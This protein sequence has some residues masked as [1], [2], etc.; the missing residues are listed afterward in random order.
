[1]TSDNPSSGREPHIA[2]MLPKLSEGGISRT[3]TTLVRGLHAYASVRVSFLL[4]HRTGRMLGVL[5]DRIAVD[6]LGCSQIRQVVP[7]LAQYLKKARPDVLLVSKET[8]AFAAMIAKLIARSPVRIFPTLHGNFSMRMERNRTS[9]ERLWLPAAVRLAYG[10]AAGIVAVSEGTADDF[11]RATGI[12]RRKVTVIRNPIDVDDVRMQAQERLDHPWLG[13]DA[14][15]IVAAGRLSE[16]KDYP[17]LLRALAKARK[18]VPLRLIVLGEGPDRAMLE[19]LIADLGLQDAVALRGFVPNPFPWMAR[20]DLLVLS[21][22]WEGLPGVLIQ[23]MCLGTPVVS[24][25]CPDG[26]REVLKGG[27]MGPLVPVGDAEALAAAIL[28]RLAA[29]RDADALRR[30]AEDYATPRV[31]DEYL[32][33]LG[34]AQSGRAETA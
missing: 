8:H 16:Q 29:P 23:A 25:D 10:R 14:P 22:R 13:G 33:L 24:T 26:P 31:V 7:A 2:V 34:M 27:A 6:E 12:D 21:S 18:T 5:P 9:L 30:R 11:A 17:T 4:E 20:A 19:A 15:S 28:S 3:R 32:Q 1:M